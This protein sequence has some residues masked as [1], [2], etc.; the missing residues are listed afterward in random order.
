MDGPNL[1]RWLNIRMHLFQNSPE[2]PSPELIGSAQWHIQVVQAPLS[3][4]AA[5]GRA[6]TGPWT[7]PPAGKTLY[8]AAS[9]G[10]ASHS[11]RHLSWSG[12]PAVLSE[13][14]LLPRSPRLPCAQVRP[15][16]SPATLK[17]RRLHSW[18]VVG[19]GCPGEHWTE[20]GLG[21]R[22]AERR[23]R[24]AFTFS[25]SGPLAWSVGRWRQHSAPRG[26][27][28]VPAD[29]TEGRLRARRKAQSCLTS[30]EG[31]ALERMSDDRALAKE[32][33]LK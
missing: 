13:A 11:G 33:N 7:V 4:W 14:P 30:T 19:S 22:W 20:W 1:Q 2:P 32:L 26:A 21:A 18:R 6:V 25:G 9:P 27:V 10:L 31:P 8:D 3:G 17:P 12:S 29:R 16:Q 5:R 23:F 28:T 15:A 24:M